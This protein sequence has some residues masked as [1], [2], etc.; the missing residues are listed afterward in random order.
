VQL[1]LDAQAA[2]DATT[3]DM[4]T[5]LYYAAQEGHTAVVQQLLGAKA[6]VHVVDDENMTPLHKAAYNG[7]TAVVQLLLNAQS[8]VDTVTL[9]AICKGSTA[10]HIAARK[11]T[12][13]WC[14][15]CWMQGRQWT[16]LLQTAK[17]P[18]TKQQVMATWQRCSCCWM[19]EQQ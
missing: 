4:L 18:C 5:A 12:L 19:R 1:L 14:S 16:L 2:V 13:Q 9:N 17:Q 6:S 7:H 15:C 3:D 8:A 11:A 10:L